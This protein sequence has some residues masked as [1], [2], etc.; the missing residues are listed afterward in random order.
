MPGAARG[1]GRNTGGVAGDTERH[2]EKKGIILRL[3]SKEN[4]EVELEINL[5]QADKPST[6]DFSRGTPRETMI[7]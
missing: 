1:D 4:G 5:S 7:K 3:N 2:T 6:T